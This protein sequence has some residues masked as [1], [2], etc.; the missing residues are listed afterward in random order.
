MKQVQI[1]INKALS[2]CIKNKVIVYPV[3]SGRRFKIQ[4]NDNGSLTTYDKEIA[5]DKVSNAQSKVY[6]YHALKILNN[7]NKT[8]EKK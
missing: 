6:K 3:M 8:I 1:D 4:V 2:I 7:A 5:G